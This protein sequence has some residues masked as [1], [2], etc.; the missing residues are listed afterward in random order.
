VILVDTKASPD[1]EKQ[2]VAELAKI[3]P[4]AGQPRPSSRIATRG[5]HER[6]RGASSGL[7]IIAHE[8]NKK[9]Q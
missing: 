6:A 9:E 1:S 7:T 8:G 4:K 3:T 2:V 5:S